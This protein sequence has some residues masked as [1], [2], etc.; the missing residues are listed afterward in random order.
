MSPFFRAY[1]GVRMKVIQL[2]FVSVALL[3]GLASVALPATSYAQQEVTASA[4]AATT[5]RSITLENDKVQTSAEH[6]YNSPAERAKDDLLITK[7]KSSLAERGISDQ[8]PVEVD[9][10]HGTIQLSGVVA[11]SDEARQAEAIALNT[12]GVVGVK[13]K[14]T[15]R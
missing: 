8:Y 9:C 2:K 11:S 5:E 14:L 3:C 15:W 6:L 12:R 4:P 13:D 1:A 10:D 7:V